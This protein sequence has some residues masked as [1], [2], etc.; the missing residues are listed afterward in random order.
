MGK[1]EPYNCNAG[2]AEGEWRSKFSGF[3]QA[4]YVNLSNRNPHSNTGLMKTKL[5]NLATS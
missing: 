2:P 5:W 4:H 3:Y 1:E